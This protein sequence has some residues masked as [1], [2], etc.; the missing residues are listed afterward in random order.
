M[1]QEKWDPG[2]QGST[3]TL[4]DRELSVTLGALE[5][6]NQVRTKT[7]PPCCCW[8]SYQ[9]EFHS[10]IQAEARL[11]PLWEW[12]GGYG[13]APLFQWVECE[14]R[15]WET[16]CQVGRQNSK[17]TSF[18]LLIPFLRWETHVCRF[19]LMGKSQLKGKGG[20]YRREKEWGRGRLRSQ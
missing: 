15:E 9:E 5:T 14:G 10:R 11:E 4:E 2:G 17:R 19:R 8:W 16:S 13:I 12:K 7:L 1:Q 18:V 20:S 3:E 6:A